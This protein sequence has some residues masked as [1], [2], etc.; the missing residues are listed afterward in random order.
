MLNHI[1]AKDEDHSH[2]DSKK[3]DHVT[4]LICRCTQN[5]ISKNYMVGCTVEVIGIVCHN[6][7]SKVLQEF[8]LS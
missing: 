1:N 8:D 6:K 5:V 4:S 7:Y 2:M 3:D